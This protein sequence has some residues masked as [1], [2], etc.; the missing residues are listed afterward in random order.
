[1]KL[2]RRGL[3]LNNVGQVHVAQHSGLSH[4]SVFKFSQILTFYPLFF[5]FL[6]LHVYSS[7]F[8]AR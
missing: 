8:L 4:P 5:V 2:E 3:V 7:K 6:R 1:M